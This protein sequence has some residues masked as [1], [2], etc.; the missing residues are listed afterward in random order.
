MVMYYFPFTEEQ[1]RE[2][3]KIVPKHLQ[4]NVFIQR[5]FYVDPE[6]FKSLVEKSERKMREALG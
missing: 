5:I 6:A 1:K 4:E 3:E 2:F